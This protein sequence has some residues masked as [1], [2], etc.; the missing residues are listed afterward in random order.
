[1]MTTSLISRPS[2]LVLIEASVPCIITQWRAFASASEFIALQEL[3]LR[4]FETHSS[5]DKPWGWV[6]DVQHLAAVPVQAQDWLL[7]DFTPRAAAAGLREFSLVQSPD[8]HHS[9]LAQHY[10]HGTT[11]SGEPYTLRTASFL[12]LESALAGARMAL[13][14]RVTVSAYH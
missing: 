9:L 14:C 3:A 11:P 2:G 7:T 4:Y 12:S 1:M 6:G 8:A 5:L 10:A 13:S